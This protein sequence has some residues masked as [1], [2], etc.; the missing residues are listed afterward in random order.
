MSKKTRY[1]GFGIA[2][3]LIAGLSAFSQK[4][5]MVDGVR[6]VHN[7][8]TG[9][10]GKEP[11]VR[12]E[13][14]RT[15]GELEAEKENVAF[16]MPSDIAL[17]KAG[18]I[19]VLDSGNHRIQK[20]GPDGHYLAT[21]GRKGQ[22]PGELYFPQSID[23]N[24]AGNIY[25]SDPNNKRIQILTPEGKELKT[26]SLIKETPGNVRCAASGEMLTARGQALVMFSP[27]E[28]E[29]K[30]LP[31]LI[32]ILDA[33]GNIKMEFG[34]PRDYGNMLVN[35][36][37][38]QADF[39]IDGK[40]NVFLAFTNQNRVEKYS[41]DGTLLWRSDR[42][43]EYSTEPADKG[44]MERQG[45][46]LSVRMPRMNTCA[47]GIAADGRGRVWVAAIR[48]QLKEE[49][50]VGM[51][52]TVNMTNGQRSMSMK[53]DGNVELRKTDAY[54]LEVYDQDGGLLGFVPLDHF[55]DGIRIVNDRLFV[56]DRMRGAQVFE[57]R[58]VEK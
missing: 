37:G 44:K 52:M 31:K 14:V 57:Y 10:W 51:A 54:R 42:E 40:D 49:E 17:D 7:G 25:L 19:Y 50:S 5:E 12:L 55:V 27:D 3:L 41:P 2:F 32:L 53:P 38:N 47:V 46:G 29:P 33:E 28:Q 48:R 30:E 22:G 35:R 23:I 26:V 8:K 4:T 56:I 43:L 13:L 18:N 21:I 36:A 15:I 20:F 58:I 39:A 24:G 11:R 9:A 1:L 16:Y 6:I 34:E 45:G